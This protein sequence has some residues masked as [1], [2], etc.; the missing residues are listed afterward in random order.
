MSYPRK[1]IKGDYYTF[2]GKM[3]ILYLRDY[4]DTETSRPDFQPGRPANPAL[5]LCGQRREVRQA[6]S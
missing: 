5:K 3:F 1:I 6:W 2:H 4:L